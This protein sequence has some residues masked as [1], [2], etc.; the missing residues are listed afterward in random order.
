MHHTQLDP[1]DGRM[2]WTRV[3][4]QDVGFVGDFVDG[5]I[6]RSRCVYIGSYGLPAPIEYEGGLA[7]DY[8]VMG[9]MPWFTDEV[10]LLDT[11]DD[12]RECRAH[13]YE[14]AIS[15]R[16]PLEAFQMVAWKSLLAVE[17]KDFRTTTGSVKYV[18]LRMCGS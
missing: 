17:N 6:D 14:G 2:E 13:A 8:C 5:T 12:Y 18:L 3:E 1:N 10:L 15:C 11:K 9:R 7:E 4:L 16:V